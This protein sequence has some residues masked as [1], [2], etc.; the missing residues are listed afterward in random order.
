MEELKPEHK[1]FSH[2]YVIDWDATRSYQVAYPKSSYDA[3]KSSASRLLTDA[4]V[5][6]YI[7]HIQQDL[8]KLAGVSQLSN[9]KKLLEIAQNDDERATDKIKSIEVINK[10]LGYNEKDNEQKNTNSGDVKVNIEFKD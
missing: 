8:Q 4:N 3:A 10:M 9:I 7:E 6:Q 2:E 1:V 5:K